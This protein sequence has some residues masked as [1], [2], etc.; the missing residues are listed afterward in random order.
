VVKNVAGYDLCKLLVGSRGRL[1]VIAEVT[2]KVRP[3][4]ESRR[5]LWMQLPG[6]AAAEQA[7][8]LLVTTATRPVAVEVFNPPAAAQ[9]TRESK[10]AIPESGVVL[11]VAFEG[12][13]HET[14]WQ[15]E[16]LSREFSALRAAA[17]ETIGPEDAHDLWTAMTEFPALSEEP[18]T[19]EAAML[20][21]RA[22]DFAQSA[23]AHGLSVQ[24]H[25]TNGVVIGHLPDSQTEAAQARELLGQLQRRAIA[26]GGMLAVLRWEEGWQAAVA[27]EFA[28]QPT[29]LE[30]RIRQ[31]LDPRGVFQAD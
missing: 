21:S 4:P 29:L 28:D 15:L 30:E 3:L 6:W 18:L 13:E 8:A 25:A 10:L 27:R 2:L 9:V 22:M 23:D 7:M 12:T 14:Q 31:T 5:L 26:S 20:P 1:A 24:V 19:I 17:V 11:C 16:T